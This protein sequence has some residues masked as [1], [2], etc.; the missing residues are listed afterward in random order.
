MSKK[1][2]KIDIDEN[3]DCSIDGQGFV[4]PECSNILREISDNLGIT[5]NTTKK[6]EYSQKLAT[7]AKTKQRA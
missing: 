1:Q 3:G 2:I 6:K 7:P 5:S 4:G